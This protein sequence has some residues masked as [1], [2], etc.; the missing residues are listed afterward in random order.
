M[1]NQQKGI[2]RQTQTGLTNQDQLEQF[3]ALY[4]LIKG[5]RD[6]DIKLYDDGKLFTRSDILELNRKVLDKLNL[7]QIETMMTTISISLDSKEILSFGSW[8]QF[9][10]YDWDISETT[11]AITIEW[12]FNVV[13]PNQ[14]H[15]LPQ[16]HTMRVRL[17][18]GVK[19][20]EFIQIVFQGGDPHELEEISSQMVCKID[21]VNTIICNELNSIVSNWYKALPKIEKEK[22]INPILGKNATRVQQIASLINFLLFSILIDSIP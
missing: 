10:S 3:K 21:F 2:S 7:H 17:G 15:N 13:F 1:E 14:Y 4:Y 6:T 11:E 18:R 12:D 9:E 16:T 5:K 20:S 19:P 8:R 22:K